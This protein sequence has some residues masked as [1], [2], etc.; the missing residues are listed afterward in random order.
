MGHQQLGHDRF[1]KPPRNSVGRALRPWFGGVLA[2]ACATAPLMAASVETTTQTRVYWVSGTT[3]AGLV[4]FMRRNPFGG[5]DG[6]A[7]A[8]IRP[9]YRLAITPRRGTD[10]CRAAGVNLDIRFV[11]TLPQARDAA[12][13]SSGTRAAWNGFVAF[14]RRHEEAHRAIYV[15]SAKAFVAKAARQTSDTCKALN[16]KIRAMFETAKRDWE[17]AQRAFDRRDSPR[18][19]GL[20]LFVMA[21]H[22]RK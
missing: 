4:S 2:L 9:H 5:D 6:P 17:R 19:L 1:P 16:A 14:A 10:I 11:M 7:V 15:S 13:M 12:R 8:N 21:R 20:K 3:A 18:L 22:S